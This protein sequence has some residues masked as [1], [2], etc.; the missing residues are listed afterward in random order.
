MAA[1]ARRR[2]RLHTTLAAAVAHPV[3]SKC[4]VILA[5]R[6]ASPSEI[7]REIHVD[8]TNV[9]YHVRGLQDANLI[10]L[11][12][13]GQVRGATE[14]FY[15]AVTLPYVDAEQEA[16]RGLPERR[17]YAESVW[18][19][20]A[21]NAANSFETGDYLRRND[22]WLS[23]FAFTVDEQGWQDAAAA[24]A[25]LEQRIFEIQKEAAERMAASDEKPMRAVSFQ[26]F[27][28]VPTTSGRDGHAGRA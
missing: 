28:E 9:G 7:A 18:S 13:L 14:H 10:E 6:V 20:V 19:I 12:E 24:H 16:E 25:E 27:F 17:T 22:H 23:R 8:V 15:R 21:A 26:S 1:A 5:E 11:V 4:L 2:K 3:R